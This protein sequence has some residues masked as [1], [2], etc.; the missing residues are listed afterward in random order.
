M[1]FKLISTTVALLW[2]V[3]KHCQLKLKSW[4]QHVSVWALTDRIKGSVEGLGTFLY[5]IIEQRPGGASSQRGCSRTTIKSPTRTL[6]KINQYQRI[7]HISPQS[8]AKNECEQNKTIWCQT[9]ATK[10]NKATTNPKFPTAKK[11]KSRVFVT[12]TWDRDRERGED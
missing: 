8:K 7:S 2:W 10:Y 5:W 1:V 9:W 12:E 3:Q 4:Q 11:T 6:M